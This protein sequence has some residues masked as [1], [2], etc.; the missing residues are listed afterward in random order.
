M[1]TADSQTDNDLQGMLGD[2]RERLHASYDERYS[3][4]AVDTA[5]DRAVDE[6]KG[7]RVRTF[8]PLLV[9]RAVRQRLPGWPG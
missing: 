7:A 2:I 5:V 4:H 1:M 3:P 8:L 6:L 9:E